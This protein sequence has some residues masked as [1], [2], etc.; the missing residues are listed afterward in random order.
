MGNKTFAYRLHL[1]EYTGN[2]IFNIIVTKNVSKKDNIPF[3]MEYEMEDS[4]FSNPSQDKDQKKAIRYYTLK[5]FLNH[6]GTS[7]TGKY[8]EPVPLDPCGELENTSS[9]N[10]NTT[11]GGSGGYSDPNAPTI[12]NSNSYVNVGYYNYYGGG[13]SKGTVEVGTGYFGRPSN[14][15]KRNNKSRKTTDT[16]C[17]I[18]EILIPVNA[19]EYPFADCA[20]FEYASAQGGL[21]KACAVNHL[22]VVVGATAWYSHGAEVRGFVLKVDGSAFFAV[23]E[24]YRNGQAANVTAIAVSAANLEIQLW[25]KANPTSSKLQTELEWGRLLKKGMKSIGGSFSTVN[26]YNVYSASNY[27]QNLKGTGNCD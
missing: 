27:I 17:P 11:S 6:L 22:N 24:L 9:S 19:E 2:S 25:F 15:Q 7:K 16:D 14:A 13:G 23:P 20:S 26:T 3:V 21:M 1:K 5:N 10:G 18:D 4:Y 8:E 12:M